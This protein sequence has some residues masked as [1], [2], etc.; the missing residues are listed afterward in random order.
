MTVRETIVRSSFRLRAAALRALGDPRGV[1]AVEYGVLAALIVV[2]CI[3]SI[4]NLG[5]AVFTELYSKIAAA[6]GAR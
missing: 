3:A 1:T 4:T 5:S 2:V 6:T